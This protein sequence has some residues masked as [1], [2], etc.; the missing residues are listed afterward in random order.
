[1]K[2]IMEN[3]REYQ[4]TDEGIGAFIPGSSERKMNNA[5]KKL[6]DPKHKSAWAKIRQEIKETGEAY[7]LLKKSFKTELSDGEQDILMTQVKDLAKGTTLAALL[8]VPG[9]SLLLPFVG[10]HLAPTAFK[11]SLRLTE[12]TAEDKA[13]DVREY[14]G[15]DLWMKGPFG[16]SD[17]EAPMVEVES[18]FVPK[19][20]RGQGIATDVMFELGRWADSN[21]Y[22]LALDPSSDFGSSVAKLKKFYSQFGFVSNKGR[23]KDF[24][25]RSAMIRPLRKK[26]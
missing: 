23:N 15:I 10:K 16:G 11:E 24:R 6:E 14:Y 26:K 5:L 1:M 13:K 12:N 2:L 22:V 4:K 25:T 7:R 3:W 21:G 19:E 20:K 9:S 18:I 8:A 17:Y